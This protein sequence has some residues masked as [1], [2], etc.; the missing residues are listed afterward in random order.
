MCIRD[1]LVCLGKYKSTTVFVFFVFHVV[2]HHANHGGT[3]RKQY[4]WLDANETL[5]LGRFSCNEQLLKLLFHISKKVCCCKM[6]NCNKVITIK[7]K[8]SA[9]A[10]LKILLHG[11]LTAIN[12]AA[13][14]A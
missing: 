2:T 5:F 11:G 1:S 13:Q 8:T 6:C 12:I 10:L 9:A 3:I 4:L 7:W 14:L